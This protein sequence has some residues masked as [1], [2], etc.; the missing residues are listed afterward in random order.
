MHTFDTPWIKSTC[1][2]CGV[3]CGIEAKALAN[4]RIEVRGDN[5]HPANLG[6]L[7]SKGLALGDTVTNEGRLLTPKV[8]GEDCSWDSALAVVANG[9]LETIKQHGPDSVAFYLSGQLLTEDY[10]LANKLMKG[11]IGSAN[12][13]TNSRLCMSSSVAG[14]KRAFGTDTMPGCYQD[15][16]HAEL[17]VLVGSNLAWCHPVLFQ[18]IKAAKA[19]YPQRKLVVI[20][21]RRTASCHD[22]DLH[23]AIKPG[24]DVMLFNGLLNY[25]AKQQLTDT[26]FIEAYTQD[27]AQTLTNAALDAPNFEH[28]AQVTACSVTDISAFYQLFGST[29]KVVSLYSQGVNQSSQGTDKVNSIINC[30]LATG[31]IGRE[32]A[33]PFSITG[34]PNAMGGR[35]VGGLANTLAAHLEFDSPEEHQ[36]LSQFWQTEKLASKPGLKALEMF[37]AIHSGKIKAIWIMA[38]NP[39]VSLPNSNKIKAALQNC[40]LVVVSD[41]IADTDTGRLAHVQLPAMGWA[42]KTGTVTNSE[43]RISRQRR[44]TT[45]PGAAR[46]DWWIISEVAK[47]M[48]FKAAFNY[49]HEGEI[50]REHAKL[51]QLA[52][53]HKQHDLDLSG[54]SN[55]SDAEYTE[56]APQQWPVTQLQTEDKTVH[57]RFFGDGKFFTPSTKAQF[58]A[59]HYLA[60]PQKTSS[61]YPLLLNT[62]RI[63]DQWHTMTRTGLSPRLSSHQGEPLLLINPQDAKQYFLSAEDIAQIDS[64]QGQAKMRVCISHDVK[65]GQL[66]APIHWSDS[67]SSAGKV[68]RLTLGL[69]DAISGQPEMKQTPVGL[70]RCNLN[71]QA[72]IV[73]RTPLSLSEFSYW[74]MQTIAGG[75]HYTVA[76]NIT[77]DEL[78]KRLQRLC[79]RQQDS[80]IQTH[81]DDVNVYRFASSKAEQIQFAYSI[82]QRLTLKHYDWFTL[83]LSQTTPQASLF[84]SLLS[85]QPQGDLAKGRIVC[86][87]K[88]VGATQLCS[89]IKQQDIKDVATLTQATQAG[90]GCGSCIGELQ[91]MITES[92]AELMTM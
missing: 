64:P 16:D 37:D 18:R 35:E 38:T 6:K 89:A 31:K 26:D 56:M 17:I 74:V 80:H 15:L 75:F 68:T 36:L 57:Q 83:L 91:Q 69:T 76:S 44:L 48:G 24:T 52:H 23:L 66:F 51:T 8:N 70:K 40:P 43:R 49:R 45:S 59:V 67:N 11:F 77:A 19:K 42:E 25:L 30:H 34:Q 47:K 84:L 14:H 86:A 13:D 41:C 1:A 33:C 22:A 5:S 90:S 4:G 10:Y 60:S 7:C 53:Q 61:A 87:C 78:N 82:S 32:G 27:F 88:Q 54:L 58:I 50:F 21:P 12:V 55:I 79:P 72:L 3:G 73:S 62:G 92:Q 81:I 71:S 2:Y 85:A 29:D 9:F 46:A 28:I 63:R 20:D 39:A 65:P